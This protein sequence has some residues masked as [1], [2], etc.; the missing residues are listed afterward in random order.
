MS[1]ITD[2]WSDTILKLIDITRAG[3]LIWKQLFPEKGESTTRNH[4][5]FVPFI[6]E[7][8]RATSR[9]NRVEI[10]VAPPGVFGYSNRRPSYR[11]TITDSSGR[12]ATSHDTS[13]IG[14]LVAA[15]KKAK[16]KESEVLESFLQGLES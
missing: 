11:L 12:T 1:A 14:D 2:K 8:F 6:L 16:H 7:V 15:I 9:H 13:A 4:P 3:T 5:S 10:T